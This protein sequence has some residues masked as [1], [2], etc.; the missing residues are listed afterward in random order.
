MGSLEYLVFAFYPVLSLGYITANIINRNHASGVSVCR[1]MTD[2][3]L[4]LLLLPQ[5]VSFYRGQVIHQG[6]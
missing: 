5:Q 3:A 1:E 2:C 6:F 4:I